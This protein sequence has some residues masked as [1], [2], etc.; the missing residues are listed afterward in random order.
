MVR[1]LERPM[2]REKQMLLEMIRYSRKGYAGI[3]RREFLQIL[4]AATAATVLPAKNAS[5]KLNLPELG[6]EAKVSLAGVGKGSGEKVLAEAIWAAA[7]SA[8][9]FSWLSK[10]DT[11]LI[12]PVLN[13]GNPYPAT[14]NPAGI[15]SIVTLLKQKGAGRVI[16]S[17]MSGIEHVKLSPNKLKGSSRTLMENCGM[18]RA[19]ETAG[20]ELYFPEED[21]WEAFFEDGP[22]SGSNWK[23]GIMMPKILR[24]VD[25]VILMP[26]CGRHALA[27]NTLGMKAAVGY[28]RTDSRLE[29]HHDAKTFHEKTAE[30]NTVSS[31][32][33]KQRL[34]LTTATRTLATFGPDKG[35]VTEP[36]TGLVI[37]SESILAHD[38]VSLAWLLENRNLVPESE[39]SHSNDPNASQAIVGFVNRLVVEWLGGVV[40]ALTA[41]RLT[42]NDTNTIWDDRTLNRAYW[43]WNA[44][45]KVN[46]N[47]AN[48]IVP[49]DVKQKLATMVSP[50]GVRQ[51][52]T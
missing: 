9:D 2:T 6:P 46:L 30:A 47:D 25:H 4:A 14:T 31:L 44:V 12:K 19:A 45:P 26:R 38:M 32:R 39:K 3:N 8:T 22:I 1:R 24:N 23:A 28:W 50:T 13:S 34:I 5:A 40:A 52:G 36:D 41:Q 20:A 10:N 17:D 16:V 7:E 27:G 35:Y 15:A 11:I 29:Y 21:G 18:A 37:A 48:D 51:E 33:E 43:L 42:R 49:S